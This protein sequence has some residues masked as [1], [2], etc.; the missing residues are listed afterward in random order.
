MRDEEKKN[1]CV[2]VNEK[3]KEE[4]RRTWRG[5]KGMKAQEENPDKEGLKE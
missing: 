3:K 5:I 4:R 1:G 2:S